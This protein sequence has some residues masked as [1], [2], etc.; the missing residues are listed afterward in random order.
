MKCSRTSSLIGGNVVALAQRLKLAPHKQ[1]AEGRLHPQLVTASCTSLARANPASGEKRFR[2]PMVSLAAPVPYSSSRPTACPRCWR[3]A[4]QTC[5]SAPSA[6]A[7]LPH[8]GPRGGQPRRRRCGR[9]RRCRSRPNPERAIARSP[10]SGSVRN[11]E[12]RRSS[13]AIL[14]SSSTSRA[15]LMEKDS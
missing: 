1:G 2:L 12:L 14:C 5:P 13:R 11:S 7:G 10:S 6:R 3:A 4:H 9:S 8:A 15:S